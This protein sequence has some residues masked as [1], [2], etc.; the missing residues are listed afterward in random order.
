MRARVE[1]VDVL[2]WY[3][4]NSVDIYFCVK[5]MFFQHPMIENPQHNNIS[6]QNYDKYWLQTCMLALCLLF[7]RTSTLVCTEVI[8]N[9]Q[10]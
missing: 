3:K 2:G 10:Y 6:I 9:I 5:G 4:S 1:K 7:I 8:A